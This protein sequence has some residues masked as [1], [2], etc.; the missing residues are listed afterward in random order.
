MQKRHFVGLL[1]MAGA[2]AN[3]RAEISA[4]TTKFQGAMRR[5]QTVARATGAKMGKAMAPAVGS[6]KNL[7]RLL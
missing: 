1:D 7:E 6:I 3:I 2:R 5:A 4:D